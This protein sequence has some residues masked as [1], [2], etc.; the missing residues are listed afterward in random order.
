MPFDFQPMRTKDDLLS[1]P[2][3]LLDDI[4]AYFAYCDSSRDERELKNG[5]LRVR[6]ITPSI[7]G[8]SQWLHVHRNT[9]NRL[10]DDP[11]NQVVDVDA[12]KQVSDILAYAKQEMILRLTAR[13][14]NGDADDRVSQAMLARYGEIG[15]D[16]TNINLQISVAGAD[17]NDVDSWS[18]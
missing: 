18:R 5:D 12:Q 4:K 10:I 9:L 13:S 17:S 15:E 1:D 11:D 7:L 6:E 2:A 3:K 14:I 16:K 8:L